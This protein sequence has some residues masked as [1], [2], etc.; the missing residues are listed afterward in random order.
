MN[1]TKYKLFSDGDVKKEEI[2]IE[3]QSIYDPKELK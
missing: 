3:K 2:K 1:K